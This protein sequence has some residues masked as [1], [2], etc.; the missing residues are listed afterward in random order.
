MDSYKHQGNRRRLIEKLRTKGIE[1]DNVLEAMGRIPRHLFMD[2]AFEDFAYEDKAFPIAAQQTISHPS[3]VALQTELMHVQPGEKVLEIGT[4]SGYQTMVLL[5]MGAQVYTIERQKELVDFSR[6]IF[7]KLGKRPRHQSFG[8]G[9]KGL[10]AFAPFHKIIVT[11]GA[12]SIPTRLLP[13]LM[14]GGLAVIPIGEKE[15]KMFTFLRV[16]ETKYEQMEFGDFR[17]VPML[18]SKE[19]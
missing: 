5:E 9:Y 14:I 19:L 12:P 18:Q 17:F 16:D 2:S 8:D 15:Q 1:D 13:Q 10:P 6:R 11:A 3:T 4:G 7:E